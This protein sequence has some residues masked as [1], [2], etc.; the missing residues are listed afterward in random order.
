MMAVTKQNDI[1]FM[2]PENRGTNSADRSTSPLTILKV[3]Q[4][5]EFNDY[6]VV[7]KG[8]K[9]SSEPRVDRAR[10]RDD[11]ILSLYLRKEDSDGQE[12]SIVVL[13]FSL[14]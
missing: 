13:E 9:F 11:N 4:N 12:P 5:G 2:L 6:D 7:W 3:T 10:L 14:S 8:G 1:Y